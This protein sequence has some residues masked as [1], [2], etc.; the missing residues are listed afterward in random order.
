MS[1]TKSTVN[2][3]L[4]MISD[5]RGES[6]VD[7]SGNRIRFVSR[8]EKDFAKRK[9]WRTHL[10]KNQTMVGTA[11]NDYTIGDATYLYR[12]KGLTEL[13]VETTGSTDMTPISL[14]Y[15]IVDF[16]NFKTL[17][18]SNTSEKM[19]YEWYDAANDLWKIHVNPAPAITE[20]LTYSYYFDVP[21]RTLTTDDIICVNPRIIA[22]IALAD[23][24]D[25]EDE[26][27]KA[28]LAKN[29]AEQ[30]IVE[31]IA[32]EDMP[33]VGQTYSMGAVEGRGFGT[34]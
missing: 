7:S 21:T 1:N 25:T 31:Q 12:P 17:Y 11:A 13:F 34:Y 6:T 16:A 26:L 2:D 23:I 18:S 24:Y 8:A 28:Q 14:S 29:E 19:V 4:Q 22:L 3:I 5:L 30:L 10:L 33:A 20:T 27:Q 32:L 9:L 15:R